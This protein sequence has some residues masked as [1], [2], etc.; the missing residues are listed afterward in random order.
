MYDEEQVIR[1]I[2]ALLKAEL[3]TEI[4]CVNT[5]KNDSITLDT[6]PADHYIFETLDSR[7]NNFRKPFIMYGL[8]ED[9]P[10][11]TQLG[12]FIEPVTV[13]VQAALFDCGEKQRVRDIYRLL[14]YRQA[15]KRVMLKNPDVFQGYSIPLIK[16]LKPSAF[17]WDNKRVILTCGLDV[18]ASITAG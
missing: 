6:I 18:T 2:E 14:R 16:R 1:D 8:V 13:T 10:S 12:N 9:D 7:V 3:N 15:I 17:P 5:I 11:S 4:A